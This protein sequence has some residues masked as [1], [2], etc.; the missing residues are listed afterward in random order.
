MT[1]L[2][3]AALAVY[4]KNAPALAERYETVD[5]DAVFAPVARLLP[6]PCATLDI[7]AGTGRDAA[8]LAAR[9]YTV[10]AVEPTEG[11]RR[12]GVVRGE[13]EVRWL[14]DSLPDLANLSGRYPFLFLNAVWHHLDAA[15]RE[16][17]LARLVELASPNAR[18]LISLRH[19]PDLPG[20]PVEQLDPEAEIAR[21]ARAG[22]ALHASRE[23][24][25][26]QPANRQAGVSWTWLALTAPARSEGDRA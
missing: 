11:L 2:S 13:A 6:P 8:W 24:P 16:A 23:A 7:G 4:A 21:A 9:G 12:V 22:F 15:E 1:G 26:V 18:L 19:G 20:Q 5:A 14:A 25:A 3:K 17:A 10:T